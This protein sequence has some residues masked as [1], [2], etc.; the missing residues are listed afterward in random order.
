M[1]QQV[2]L[3]GEKRISI[4]DNPT[5]EKVATMI[6]NLSDHYPEMFDGNTIGEVDRKIREIVWLENGL[7]TILTSDEK[8]ADKVRAWEKW[9]ANPQ[10]CVDSETLTRARRHLVEKGLVRLKA[11]AIK[12]GE[13][14]RSRLSKSFRRK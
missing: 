12:Q 14:E 10:Q 7:Y 13:R 8:G 4:P 6:L 3:F 1:E 5:L 2:D 11:S 9:N